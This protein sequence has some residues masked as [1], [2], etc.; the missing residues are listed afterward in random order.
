MISV[1]RIFILSFLFLAV[2]CTKNEFKLEFH[3]PQDISANYKTIYYAAG[4]EGGLTLEHVVAI[5]EGKGEYTGFTRIPTLVSIYDNSLK[6]PCVIY[7]ER[8]KTIKITGDTKNPISWEIENDKINK[9]LTSW[10]KEN[11][12]V[13]MG[14]KADEINKAVEKFVKENLDNPV[15]TIILLNYF[16][17][18]EDEKLYEKLWRELDAKAKDQKWISLTSRADQP[19]E[20]LKTLGRLGTWPLRSYENRTDTLSLSGRKASLL[21]FWITG[22][23]SNRMF[24]D[25]LTSLSQEFPDIDKR[26]IADICLDADSS[27][28]RN[29]LR[30]DSVSKRFRLWTPHGIADKKAMD[31]GIFSTPFII[32][33]DSTGTQIYRGEDIDMA[34]SDFRALIKK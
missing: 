5:A 3:L 27:A 14:G 24:F 32:V 7:V 33:T 15:S 21:F 10:R 22:D 9:A 12:E 13:L 28:W 16:S 8:G 29:T 31:L 17:R 23:M 25:S 1:I 6:P 30:H 34:L 20:N 26:L 4:K 18:M 11:L 19:T 2:S